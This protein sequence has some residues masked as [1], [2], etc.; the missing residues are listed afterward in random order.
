MKKLGLLTREMS[1]K[2]P[3][4]EFITLTGLNILQNVVI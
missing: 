1:D 4:A 3:N 2:N